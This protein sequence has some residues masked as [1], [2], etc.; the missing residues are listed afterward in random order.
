MYVRLI[1]C[2]ICAQHWRV[3]ATGASAV[4][5]GSGTFKIHL[6]AWTRPATAIRCTVAPYA[7][8]VSSKVETPF[9]SRI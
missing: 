9:Y 8:S 5:T 7:H 2:V 3:G 1:I 6:S 4:Y